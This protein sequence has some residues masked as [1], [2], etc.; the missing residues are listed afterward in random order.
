MNQ[1]HQFCFHFI[2]EAVKKGVLTS[3]Y[4]PVNK[5]S[6]LSKN[7][8]NFTFIVHALQLEQATEAHVSLSFVLVIV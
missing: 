1:A 5:Q 3:I 4:C 7:I 8:Y 6:L 2:Q